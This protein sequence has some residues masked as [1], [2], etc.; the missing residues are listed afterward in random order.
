AAPVPAPEP[1]PSSAERYDEHAFAVIGMAGRFPDPPTLDGIWAHLAAGPR[2]H[3]E[4]PPDRCDT[5]DHYDPEWRPG[6]TTSKWAASL[7]GIDAFDAPFFRMSPLEAEDMDPEQ[8]LF[9]T[10]AWRALEDAGYAVGPETPLSCGVF[11]GCT[12][13]DYRQIR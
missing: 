10:E 4:V 5:A 7:S 8:R 9:L 12:Q 11:V 6:T 13:S 1:S 3:G 2:R